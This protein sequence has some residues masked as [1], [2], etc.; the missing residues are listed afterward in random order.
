MNIW[1]R[2]L[3][4]TPIIAATPD[5]D[6]PEWPADAFLPLDPQDLM[7]REAPL[8]DSTARADA[9]DCSSDDHEHEALEPEEVAF[10]PLEN[11]DLL[12]ADF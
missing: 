9:S 1:R 8:H 12:L 2:Q 10:D 3:I 7:L 11:L 5:H 4:G 6:I